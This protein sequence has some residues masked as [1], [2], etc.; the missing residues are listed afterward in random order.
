MV[1]SFLGA[2]VMPPLSPTLS[3]CLIAP[4]RE[5]PEH[6]ERVSGTGGGGGGGAWK[7]GQQHR[8][9]STGSGDCMCQ[10]L[11]DCVSVCIYVFLVN[12]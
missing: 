5:I 2:S 7:Q 6:R 3:P 8:R 11:Y 9:G 1:I 10:R 4:G 12:V